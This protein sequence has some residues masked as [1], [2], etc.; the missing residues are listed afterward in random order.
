MIK[1]KRI[2]FQNFLSF[3][4][5]QEFIFSEE[6]GFHLIQG[7]VKDAEEDKSN[8]AG[9]SSFTYG[10]QYAIFGKINKKIKKDNVV[11]KIQEKDLE[12]E[13]E[14]DIDNVEYRIKRYRKHS[15]F[16]N[17]LQLFQKNGKSWKDISSSDS[18]ITQKDI[19]DLIVINHETFLKSILFSRDG[20]R[21]FLELTNTE[22]GNIFENIIQLA[23]LKKYLENVKK[24]LKEVIGDISSRK[25]EISILIGENQSNERHIHTTMASLHQQRD[26]INKEINRLETDIKLFGDPD[27]ILGIMKEY[28]SLHAERKEIVDNIEKIEEIAKGF[29]SKIVDYIGEIKESNQDNNELQKKLD[30]ADSIICEKCGHKNII[31]DS[32]AIKTLITTNANHISI[33]HE[34]IEDY[35]SQR[36]NHIEKIGK[37][38]EKLARVD[39]NI[40]DAKLS[41]DI[42]D[43]LI[44]DSSVINQVIGLKKELEI[45]VKTL[46]NIDVTPI[47][48]LR[49]DMRHNKSKMKDIAKKIK[50]LQSKKDML[51]YLS[52]I[53]DIKQENSIKQHII[54]K[55]IPVFNNSL[56]DIVDII[57]DGNMLVSFDSFLN[58]TIYFNNKG[59]AYGELST[60]EKNALNLCINL[61][62]FDLTRINLNGSNTIFLDEIFTNL[63]KSFIYKFIHLV[64]D[65]YTETSSV[66][67]ISHNKTVEENIN[68]KTNILIEKS[69][70]KSFIKSN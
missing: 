51:D 16:K 64:A 37:L 58:E 23:K 59:Y 60:G 69:N 63:D 15:Q 48:V 45:Q 39:D 66:Y 18:S 20:T 67:V 46:K 55:I 52:V 28:I 9:K 14:F 12:V 1:F 17:G 56:Q 40:A 32:E 49:K 42:K 53:L 11:N 4:D 13:L 50:A 61:S 25:S 21:E 57:F 35:E 36:D 30:D 5:K 22:R 68:P 43:I 54:N 29:Q 24:K 70:G 27:K 47:R 7:K 3:Q 38:S 19:D 44:V 2:S 8:G 65:K 31:G 41:Q 6:K 34:L 26:N 62:I 33:L 10:P